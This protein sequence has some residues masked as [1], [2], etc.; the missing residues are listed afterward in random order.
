MLD[1]AKIN[2]FILKMKI[3][4]E[5]FLSVQPIAKGCQEKYDPTPRGNVA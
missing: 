3:I 1:E 2:L 5:K 4:I